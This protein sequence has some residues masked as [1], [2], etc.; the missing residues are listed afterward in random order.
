MLIG[1]GHHPDSR[2]SDMR[3]S[4]GYGGWCLHRAVLYVSLFEIIDRPRPAAILNCIM[5]LVLYPWVVMILRLN[6]TIMLS[7]NIQLKAKYFE[8]SVHRNE[9]L[10]L[11]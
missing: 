2:E 8:T 4:D 11:W 10:S 1:I 5:R 7:G 3:Q 6:Y 9:C